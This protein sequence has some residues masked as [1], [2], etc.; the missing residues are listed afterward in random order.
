MLCATRERSGAAT[1]SCSLPGSEAAEPLGSTG[2]SSQSHSSPAPWMSRTGEERPSEQVIFS[3]LLQDKEDGEPKTKQ[4]RE[5][6]EEG[7]KHR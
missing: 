1:S 5:G 3:L 6:E 7:E 4:L 2:Q